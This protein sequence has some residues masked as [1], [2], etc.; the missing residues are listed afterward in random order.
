MQNTIHLIIL[1]VSV[2][3]TAIVISMVVYVFRVGNLNYN[4]FASRVSSLLASTGEVEFVNYRGQYVDGKT[5]RAMIEE[6]GGEYLIRV[7]TKKNPVGF[8]IVSKPVK[9]KILTKFS[10]GGEY[11]DYTS[12]SSFYYIRSG[13][14][15]MTTLIRDDWGE[16]VGATFNEKGSG[17]VTQ[18][19]MDAYNGGS[20]CSLETAKALYYQ[21]LY[22]DL[23]ALTSS[24]LSSTLVQL[25]TDISSVNNE[26]DSLKQKG[27]SSVDVSVNQE[28]NLAKAAAASASSAADAAWNKLIDAYEKENGKIALGHVTISENN[29]SSNLDDSSNLQYWVNLFNGR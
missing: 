18:E 19:V 7:Q 25:K 17:H 21:A 29:T 10:N 9:N 4:E 2:V 6:Y 14:Q 24:E 12:A 8:A 15:F 1:G 20:D 22:T 11:S 3:V 23:S 13:S 5:V 28:Y 26:I 16:V 27:H